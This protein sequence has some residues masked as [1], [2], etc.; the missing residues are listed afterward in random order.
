MWLIFISKGELAAEPCKVLGM[1][2]VKAK[3]EESIK[4][5]TEEDIQHCF[6]QC[7]IWMERYMDCQGEYLEGDKVSDDIG[8]D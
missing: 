3:M 8:N 4:K 1:A 6:A 5:L 2:S 7:K